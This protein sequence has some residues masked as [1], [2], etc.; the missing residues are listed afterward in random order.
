MDK[1]HLYSAISKA[2]RHLKRVG[3]ISRPAD[4]IVGRVE[5]SQFST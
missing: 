2:Q 4:Q 3:A 5:E 1:R